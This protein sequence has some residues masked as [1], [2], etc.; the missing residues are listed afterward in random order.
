MEEPRTQLE[1]PP[2]GLGKGSHGLVQQGW[3]LAWQRQAGSTDG[4]SIGEGKTF[5]ALP[6]VVVNERLSLVLICLLTAAEKRYISF[7]RV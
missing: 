7:L 4:P 6:M 5:C 1:D 2:P 3:A